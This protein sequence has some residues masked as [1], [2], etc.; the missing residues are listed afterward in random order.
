MKS[1]R[2]FSPILHAFG[3]S[4]QIFLKV[5]HINPKEIPLVGVAVM[6][7]NRRAGRQTEGH[8][9]ANSRFSQ[10]WESV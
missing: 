3:F 10:L 6:H 2:Y 4:Q 9:E 5:L 1:A 8:D 7:A